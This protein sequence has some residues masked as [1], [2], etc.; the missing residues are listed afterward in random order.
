MRKVIKTVKKKWMTQEVL[1]VV[2]E[3]HKAYKKYRKLRT[4]ESKEDYN[5]AKHMAIYV[6]NKARTD[7]ET[8]IATI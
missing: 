8:R 5:R 7:V 3:K 4:N 1:N 6:T 2:K